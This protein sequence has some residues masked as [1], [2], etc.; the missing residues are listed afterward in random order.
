MYILDVGDVIFYGLL[1][2]IVGIFFLAIVAQ[3]IISFDIRWPPIK[4]KK[5]KFK[6]GTK[7]KLPKQIL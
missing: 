6:N 7:N 1:G 3:I 4:R 2:I 5:G